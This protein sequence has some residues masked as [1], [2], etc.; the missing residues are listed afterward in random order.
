MATIEK[1]AT[2]NAIEREAL[3]WMDDPHAH[4]GYS[5]TKVHSVPREEAQA[6]QLAGINLRLEQR[7]GQ[8]KVL[9]KLWY[10]ES[11]VYTKPA[12]GAHDAA[13]DIQRSI[14]ELRHYRATLFRSAM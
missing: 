13:V 10:G 8:I 12:E 9:A 5:V 1:R 3:A 6:V 2:D 11:A 7:R 4:F 14:A